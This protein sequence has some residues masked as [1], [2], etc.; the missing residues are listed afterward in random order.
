MAIAQP[1]IFALG[2]RYHHH[3]EFRVRPE[4]SD[5]EIRG[6]IVDLFAPAAVPGESNLV[7]GFASAL[8]TRLHPVV[9]PAKLRPF[10]GISGADGRGVP[11]KQH[12]VWVWVHGGGADVVFDLARRAASALLPVAAVA[13]EQPGFIFRQSR[14]LTGFE[15][16]TENPPIDEAPEVALVPHGQ[17]GAGGSYAIVMRWFHDLAAFDA[18]SPEEQQAVFGRTKDGSLEID[19]RP[20]TSHISRVVIDEGGGE[21]EIFRRSSTFGDVRR[22]GLF[23]VAFSADPDR[24]ER[25]LGRM[26]GDDGITD[27][28]TDFSRPEGGAYYFVPSLEDL[29]GVQRS[30][31]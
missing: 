11:A 23:F 12:D 18:L 24:F 20:A 27:R 3:I 8:W 7:A 14:D 21:L 26:Y 16:G 28:L 29:R 25:M 19:E 1:G 4:A 2:S 15:D 22:H 30:G 17:A 10:P 9:S 5:A 31:K 13:D 6:A